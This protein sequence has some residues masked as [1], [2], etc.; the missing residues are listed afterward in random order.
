MENENNITLSGSGK[1]AGIVSYFGLIGWLV[2][3]FGLHRDRKT[4]LGSYQLRQTLLFAIA[5]TVICMVLGFLLG[6]L[7]VATGIAAIGYLGTA[8]YIVLLIIWLI[9][10]IGAI[11]GEQKP[12]PL[13]GEKAQKMFPNI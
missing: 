10:F 6:M 3:Y 8:I 7:I 12:M 2:A 13:I 4:A 11:K 5:S 9:G 1:V